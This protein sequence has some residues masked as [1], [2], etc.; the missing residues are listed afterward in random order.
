M[1]KILLIGKLDELNKDLDSCISDYY[2]VQKCINNA[3]LVANMVNT[4]N[5]DLVIISLVDIGENGGKILKE[6]KINYSEIPVVVI[7]NVNEQYEFSRYL[8]V[9]QFYRVTRPVSNEEILDVVI[10]KLEKNASA[11]KA[12]SNNKGGRKKIL[13]VDDVMTSGA[14]FIELRRTLMAC[15]AVAVYGVTFC[16]VVRAI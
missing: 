2:S 11:L 15:G 9:E 16:R 6:F 10:N 13:L 8:G 4:Q 14:T 3:G 1:K 12:N 5:P 7:G